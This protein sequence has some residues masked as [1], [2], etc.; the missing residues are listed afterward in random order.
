M[1]ISN[2][3]RQF[4]RF[5]GPNGQ[6]YADCLVPDTE[7]CSDRVHVM[8][9]GGMHAGNCWIATPDDRLGW[10]PM[11]AA[12]GDQVLCLDWPGCGR[13]GYIP[14]E[15]ITSDLVVDLISAA[16]RELEGRRILWVHSMSGPFGW[17]I[18]EKL[19]D[20]LTSLV[21]IAPGPPGNIQPNAPILS[22]GEDGLTAS[23][24]DRP[25]RVPRGSIF[26]PER[27]FAHFKFVKGS[28]HFPTEA[29]DRYFASLL[30]IP[31][32]LLLDR[33]NV[34]G[35]QLRIEQP[36]R[37]ADTQVI[38]VTGENDPD[39]SREVDEKI[40][41][42]LQTQGVNS[43]YMFLPRH[44]ILGNGHMMMIERNNAE[45]LDRI[46]ERVVAGGKPVS[47]GHNYSLNDGH[48]N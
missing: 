39:H 26:A 38:I 41:D 22:Q 33:L 3:I 18:A 29:F 35:R 30:G 31:V 40:H 11:I 10:A 48:T 15:E 17:K 43:E 2:E 36:G 1:N 13:S 19:G 45:I 9:H 44:H 12:R 32:N 14:P 21:A 46:Y 34:E 16:L 37:L 25:W 23:L 42:F 28:K 7:T 20:Q 4:P 24:L 27:S 47:R 5:L 8:V 6:I